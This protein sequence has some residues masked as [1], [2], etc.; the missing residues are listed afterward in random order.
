MNS[1]N[2]Q[3]TK[4]NV[5]KSVVFLY[6]NNAAEKEIKKTIP[7]STAPKIIKY[8]GMNSTKKEKDLYSEKYKA[9]IKEI[10]DDTKKRRHS[11]L[12]DWKKKYC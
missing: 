2:S 6:T 5:Q 9:L 7:I 4:I 10:E 11:M 8:L 3:D 12:M 1:V